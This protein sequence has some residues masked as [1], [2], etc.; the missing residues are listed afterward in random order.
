M[1]SLPRARDLAR[2]VRAPAALSVPGDILAGAA[3]ARLPYRPELLGMVASSVCLYW[4][5]MALNDYAD[6]DLDAVERP[7]RPIPSGAVT[8]AE[9]RAV[10]GGLTAAGLG[11][12]ALARGRRGLATAVPL[13]GAVWAYDLALKPTPAGAAA[14][15]AARALNVLG[16]AGPGGLRAALPAAAAVGV[17]TGMVTRLSR[18]E[19]SGAPRSV[20]RQSLAVGAAVSAAVLLRGHRR[21]PRDRA[22]AAALT[23]VYAYGGSAAQLTAART[24]S[25]PHVRRAVAAG[26]HALIPLQA[27]LTA[28][29]GR[30]TEGAA[31][32]C[33]LPWAR[34]LGR[35]V[36]PT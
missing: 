24:P 18:Y 16:G 9:A 12:A 33:A 7:E 34:R 27:A 19:V 20:P 35:K 23:A 31:L 13:A 32:A 22:L 1:S 15:A 26:I 36:S 14:M 8:P 25:A 3:A 29:A 2:L 30:G 17:H 5:G 6:R 10:A 28:T 21:P 4:A 11:L